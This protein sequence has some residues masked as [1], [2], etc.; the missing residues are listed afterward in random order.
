MSTRWPFEPLVRELI[1]I[2]ARGQYAEA[3]QRTAGVRLSAREIEIAV[4]EYGRRLVPAPE[5][6]A[7]LLDVVEVQDAA[8]PAWCVWTRLWTAEEGRSDLT[9][10]LTVWARPESG[11]QAEI[12]GILVP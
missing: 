3:E 10:Q 5:G 9:L 1:T 11:Y 4:A 2:L 8:P 7:L 6:G 12:D